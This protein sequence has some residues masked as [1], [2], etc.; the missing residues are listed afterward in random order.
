M[1]IFPKV[2]SFLFVLFFVFKWLHP[3]HA[4]VPGPGIESK[5]QL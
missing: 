1:K 2:T 4:E 5:L 3:Q